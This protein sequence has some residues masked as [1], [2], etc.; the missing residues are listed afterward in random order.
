MGRS[1][2]CKLRKCLEWKVRCGIEIEIYIYIYIV[3]KC[4][5][6]MSSWL[7]QDGGGMFH[8]LICSFGVLV[9]F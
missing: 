6:Q 3:E 4:V 7:G 2:G 8:T 5:P 1:S 9:N